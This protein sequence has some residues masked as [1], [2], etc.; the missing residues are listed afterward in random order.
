MCVPDEARTIDEFRLIEKRVIAKS[1]TRIA[2]QDMWAAAHKQ[3]VQLGKFWI[4][5]SA[6]R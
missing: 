5:L 4:S 3:T 6:A 1:T 2:L